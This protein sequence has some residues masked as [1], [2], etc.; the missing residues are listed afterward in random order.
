MKKILLTLL[1]MCVTAMI[2]FA[3][4]KIE[5]YCEVRVSKRTFS[6][7]FTAKIIYG[8]NSLIISSDKS[9]VSKNFQTLPDALNYIG[10]LGW[11][12]VSAETTDFQYNSRSFIFKKEFTRTEE[13]QQST[14]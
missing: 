3:Q 8:T 5:Q 14:N 13:K 2:G 11:K 12:L 7:G 6:E 4:D 9:E 10:A 1:L